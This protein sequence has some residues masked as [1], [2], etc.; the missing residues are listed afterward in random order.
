MPAYKTLGFAGMVAEDPIHFAEGLPEKAVPGPGIPRSHL[1]PRRVKA[2]DGA[3]PNQCVVA[4]NPAVAFL[5]GQPAE[6]SEVQ[7]RHR[8]ERR[9]RRKVD[10]P[11]HLGI[12]GQ[13]VKIPAGFQRREEISQKP[14][15]AVPVRIGLGF[16]LHHQVDLPAVAADHFGERRHLGAFFPQTRQRNVAGPQVPAEHPPQVGVMDHHRLQVPGPAQVELDAPDALRD[17]PIESGQGVFENPAVVVLAAMGNDPAA[18]KPFHARMRLG[19]KG[20]N[21]VDGCQQKVFEPFEETHAGG[22]IH[23]RIRISAASRFLFRKSFNRSI[24][25][26]VFRSQT[27]QAARRS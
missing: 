13:Q 25:R 4:G 10:Q 19:P 12:E 8:D 2:S 20:V 22:S 11:K 5:H 6:A 23:L 26:G 3:I 24:G 18:P 17:R 16:Y 21:P 27:I 15:P 7:A 1:L 9:R 14:V